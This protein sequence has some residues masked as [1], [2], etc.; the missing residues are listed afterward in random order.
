MRHTIANDLDDEGNSRA[1]KRARYDMELDFSTQSTQ[2]TNS[3]IEDL[4]PGPADATQDHGQKADPPHQLTQSE[5]AARIKR[6]EIRQAHR[7]LQEHADPGLFQVNRLPFNWPTETEDR[8]DPAREEGREE[9]TII[10]E[11]PCLNPSAAGRPFRSET[12][13]S[14][15]IVDL[16]GD[17]TASPLLGTQQADSQHT[18]VLNLS[19]SESAFDSQEHGSAVDGLQDHERG[20]DSLSRSRSSRIAAYLAAREG[21]FAAWREVSLVSAGDNHAEEEIEL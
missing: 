21:T 4:R 9:D 3:E 17:G 6:N 18:D 19:V 12:T 15:K 5:E 11:Q 13:T 16:T 1:R 14:T 7:Y 2:E 10:P 20:Q 8:F